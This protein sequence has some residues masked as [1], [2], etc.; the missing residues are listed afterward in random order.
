MN[1]ILTQKDADFILSYIRADL[2]KITETNVKLVE[3]KK[4]FVSEL[5]KQ[6]VN[7]DSFAGNVA[8]NLLSFSEELTNTTDK[9][10]KDL[11]RCVELLTVGSEATE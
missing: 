11:V 3:R 8:K 1:I 9:I 10:E 6:G 4:E 7:A 2:Q 5:E